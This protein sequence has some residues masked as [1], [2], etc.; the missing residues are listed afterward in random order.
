[1][2][3]HDCSSVLQV[4]ARYLMCVS[5]ARVKRGSK[6]NRKVIN[7]SLAI[8]KT[9]RRRCCLHFNL[10]KLWLTG[11]DLQGESIRVLLSGCAAVGGERPRYTT[12]GVGVSPQDSIRPGSYQDLEYILS[13][14][15]QLHSVVRNAELG[16]KLDICLHYIMFYS[17][18][19]FICKL[20]Q[21]DLTS[22][23]GLGYSSLSQSRQQVMQIPTMLMLTGNCCV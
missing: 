12:A 21:H 13:G 16:V 10:E 22:H 17:P 8:S 18:E 1:M 14:A 5:S 20:W 23:P 15:W 9:C 7:Y 3:S 2:I 4:A 19:G 11:V 6:V